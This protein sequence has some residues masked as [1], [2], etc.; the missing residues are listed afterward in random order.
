MID[1]FFKKW[2]FLSVFIRKADIGGDIF[3]LLV[4]SW[5]LNGQDCLCLL[6]G[7][8]HPKSYPWLLC[9][10]IRMEPDWDVEQPRLEPV[11]IQDASS[12]GGSF[13]HHAITL[14]PH[15]PALSSFW[16]VKAW[17]AWVGRNTG[18]KQDMLTEMNARRAIC[19][20]FQ[21]LKIYLKGLRRDFDLLHSSVD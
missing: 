8:R 19:L 21:Y 20:S 17:H 6:L 4:H 14:G 16:L 1:T 12:A 15:S 13:S 11:T 18:S 3:H 2:L 9:S 7:N 5:S 10:C